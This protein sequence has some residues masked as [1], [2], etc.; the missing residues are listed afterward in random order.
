MH[1]FFKGEFFHFE[2]VR[3]LGMT[4]HGGAD[5]AEVLEAVGKI[6]DGD[7]S[8]WEKAWA[9]QARRAEALAEEACEN[10]DRIAARRAYLRASNYTRAAAYMR[11]GDGPNRPDP[12]HVNVCEKVNGLFRKA[13]ALFD[14]GVEYL[15]IPFDEKIS[16]PGILY[17]PPPNR[18]TS[19]KIPVLIATGGADALQE[20]LYYMHPAVGPDLG[21]AV[22]TFEGPGQG[23]TLRRH[24]IKM[25]P[26]WEVV[27]SSV[28]NYIEKLSESHPEFDLDVSRIAIAGAS[29][30]GYFALR[31]AADPRIKACVAIDPVYSMWDFVTAH[32]SPAFIGAW[33]RGWLSN[34]FVDFFIHM[35]MWSAFQ[36]RWEVSISGT[37]F[38]ITSPASIMQEMKR[39]SLTLPGDKSYLDRVKCPVLVSGASESLYI[40]AN[41]HTM[42]VISGLKHQAEVD[43]EVW[44]AN[45]PGQG[46]L[47]AKMG[48]MQLVNQKTFKFLDRHFGIQ[49]QQIL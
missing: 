7:P 21:Y 11:P 13:T 34:R 48:A 22:L 26:D 10:G 35:G 15:T 39:Y 24:D 9:T 5:V 4:P 14:C 31:A 16:F 12:R 47:Q 29:L 32:V 1:R 19:G 17:L 43:K 27:V 6:K 38:G 2:T 28:L 40:E 37:F 25:R 20:E 42:R 49:R 46:S 18:R 3:I 23:L 45:T 36:M 8:S 33:E 44:M 41:R 30:G